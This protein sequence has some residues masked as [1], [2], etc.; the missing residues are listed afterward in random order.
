MTI[1]LSYQNGPAER[2]IGTAEASMHAMLHDT[3]LPLGFG[4][5]AICA[6]VYLRNR[7]NTG[8]TIDGKITSPEES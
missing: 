3:G 2:S 5:T 7:T 8:P 4:D 1:A 6:D